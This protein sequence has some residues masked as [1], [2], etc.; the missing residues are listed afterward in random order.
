VPG[1]SRH[2]RRILPLDLASEPSLGAWNDALDY[3]GREYRVAL[4]QRTVFESEM[5]P[6]S[7]Y[8]VMSHV[9]DYLQLPGR[10][11]TI[12]SA[13]D[14]YEL[15]SRGLPVGSLRNF[16][17]LMST[18]LHYL[19]GREI[20]IDL[21]E[22]DPSSDLR[23]HLDVLRFWRR[24]LHGLFGVERLPTPELAGTVRPLHR[25]RVEQIIGELIPAEPD[26]ASVVRRFGATLTSYCFLENCDSRL[27]TCDT[28]PYAIDGDRHLALRELIID[29]DGRYPWVDAIR[30]QL[31]RHAFVIAYELPRSVSMSVNV[32]GTAAFHPSDYHAKATGLRVYAVDHDRLLPLTI[33]EL[34]PLI[35]TFEAAQERLYRDFAQMS[36]QDRTLCGVHMYAWKTKSWATAAGCLDRIDWSLSPRVLGLYERYAET[37]DASRTFADAVISNQ[38]PGSFRPLQ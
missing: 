4:E 13:V 36:R 21:G 12:A 24:G 32:W 14:P 33:A 9:E 38:R 22:I 2:L 1:R 8:V 10:L 25:D 27:A 5:F 31:P 3:L 18:L 30:D 34:R 6:I 28:G 7:A 26:V 37:L 19:S 17:G 16:I 20:L 35:R 23:D 11:R 29:C 15:F